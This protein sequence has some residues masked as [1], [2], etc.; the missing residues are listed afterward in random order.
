MEKKYGQK[1]LQKIYSDKLLKNQDISLMNT[2]N[3]C[4][5]FFFFIN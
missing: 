2:G 3:G 5:K 4:R 1:D